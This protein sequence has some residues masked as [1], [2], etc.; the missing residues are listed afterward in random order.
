MSGAGIVIAGG[1]YAGLNAAV[2]ARSAGYTGPVTLV[3]I[4]PHLPYQRPPLSKEFLRGGSEAAQPLRPA[5]FFET[6]NIAVRSGNTVRAIDRAGKT[7]LL[8]GGATLPYDKLVLATGTRPRLLQVPG[9]DAAGILCLRTLDDAQAIAARLP[10]AQSVVVVGGGFIGLEIAASLRRMGKA[11]CVLES[12]QRLLSRA[13]AP[14]MAEYIAGWHA[15]EGVD[16][17]YGAQVTRFHVS[18]GQVTAAELADGTVLA[19]GLVVVGIGVVPNQ[20]LAQEAGIACGNGVV[21]DAQCRTSDPDVY[22]AGDCTS[23]PN[24]F[25]EGLTRLECVQNATDQ[26]R[27]AGANAAGGSSAYAAPP[28]FWSDQYE[29]KLQ[30]TGISTG[31]DRVVQ[32]GAMDTHAFSTF[33]FAGDRLLAVESVNKP[34]EHMLARRLLAGGIVP[35]DAQVADT[36]FELKQLLAK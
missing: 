4:E 26:G 3:G 17:R 36:G 20:E 23:H 12:Q 8:E 19:A 15:R 6:S 13:L 10:T 22:A 30:G 7:L 2:A 35:T 27:I 1:S 25:A 16:I 24:P 14:A 31:Y 33:Y 28:W 5:A 11:V 18:G 34:G 29:V 21:V 32:R 9:S